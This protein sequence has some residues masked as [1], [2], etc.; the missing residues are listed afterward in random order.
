MENR[1]ECFSDIQATLFISVISQKNSPVSRFP[2]KFFLSKQA[3]LEFSFL[4]CCSTYPMVNPQITNPCGHALCGHCADRLSGGSRTCHMCRQP[5]TGF[6]RN[7]FAEQLL[8]NVKVKCK[9]CNEDVPLNVAQ[10]HVT[11]HC[12]EMEINCTQ[13]QASIKRKEAD[14]HNS[15]CPKGEI[16]CECGF[17]MCRGDGEQHQK[18]CK[19]ADVDCRLGCGATIK[20]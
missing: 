3:F 5:R 20:R 14:V 12:Q 1:P 16:I 2:G 10:Q 6:C 13:C 7:I 15:S 4:I 9:S 17:K 8:A 18:D 19:M 11:V